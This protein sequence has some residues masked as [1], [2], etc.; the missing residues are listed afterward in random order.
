MSEI[1][2]QNTPE[3]SGS[4]LFFSLL[5]PFQ[6]LITL[7]AVEKVHWEVPG[8]LS[9]LSIRLDFGP[10]HDLTAGGIEPHARFCIDSMEPA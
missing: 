5:S 2:Q 3:P 6:E 9:Q 4:Q 1:H 10:G 8:W 7:L